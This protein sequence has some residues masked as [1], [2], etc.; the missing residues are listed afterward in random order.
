LHDRS[1][2]GLLVTYYDSQAIPRFHGVGGFGDPYADSA[3]LGSNSGH[4]WGG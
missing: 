4:G 2:D 1:I 3:D